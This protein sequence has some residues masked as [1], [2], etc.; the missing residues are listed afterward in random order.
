MKH[1]NAME[2]FRSIDNQAIKSAEPILRQKVLEQARRS[3]VRFWVLLCCLLGP[4]RA[5]EAISRATRDAARQVGPIIRPNLPPNSELARELRAIPR[6][7]I[8][9]ELTRRV[10]DSIIIK[11]EGIAE[12]TMRQ[13]LLRL[14]YWG[15][16]VLFI[17]THA[18]HWIVL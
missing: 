1:M 3:D 17:L 7:V 11:M 18:I 4:R 8:D 9:E 2:M 14:I 13:E 16:A 10:I 6:D 15:S 5:P 12:T